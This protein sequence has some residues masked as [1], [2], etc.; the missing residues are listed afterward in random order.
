[1][2]ME[3]SSRK[4]VLH[5]PEP[6]RN[7]AI[8]GISALIAPLTRPV[9]QK[10]APAAYQIMADWET[11]AGPEIAA[12]SRPVKFAGGT[13]TL[14][15]SGPAAMELQYRS[16]MLIQRL[17]S[18]LGGTRIER[19]KFLQEA[20]PVPAAAIKKLPKRIPTPPE[21]LPDGPLGEALGKLYQGIA[22]S[23]E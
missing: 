5:L 12:V 10:R 15:C 1:M 14:G 23:R 18:G 7:F 3:K 21:G 8:R 16:D 13:L 2:R 22:G 11:L 19:L 6:T 4:P 17:N 20:Q 9:F